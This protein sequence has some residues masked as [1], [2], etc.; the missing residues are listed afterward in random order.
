MERSHVA[1]RSGDLSRAT[2]ELEL[3]LPE[4]PDDYALTLRLAWLLFLQQRY[5]EAERAYRA[6]SRVSKDAPLARLGLSWSLVRQQRCDEARQVLASVDTTD[7]TA[8]LV[9][10]IAACEQATRVHGSVWSALGGARYSDHPWKSRSADLSLGMALALPV[11]WSLGASYRGLR[12]QANDARVPNVDQHEGYLQAGYAGASFGLSLHGALLFAGY[13]TLG[14]SE[15]IALAARWTSVGDALLELT[16]SIYPD[17][18]VARIAPAWAVRLGRYRLVSGLSVEH[19]ARETLL[20]GSLSAS[21]DVSFF[22]LSAGGKYGPE[23]RAAYLSRSA[24]FN[25]EDRSEWG[26]WLSVR[27][28]VSAHLELFATFTLIQ[29]TSP[30]KI[31]SYVQ[32]L[33]L[34]ASCVF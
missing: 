7:D 21:V 16:A 33:G 32:L 28:G 4:Y 23:Y 30:D 17:L 1:E 10:A 34:G 5:A 8:P 31:V 12:L 22:S 27:T 11:H 6:A 26:A 3:A 9:A 13:S 19:F 24:V 14:R 20:S 25:S 18:L 15:H 2:L 29:L